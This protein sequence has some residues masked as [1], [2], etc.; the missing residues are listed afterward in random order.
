MT[1]YGTDNPYCGIC[2]IYKRGNCGGF[3]PDCEV[4]ELSDSSVMSALQGHELLR[5]NPL[6]RSALL[7]GSSTGVLIMKG[8]YLCVTLKDTEEYEKTESLK[9]LTGS[10][11]ILESDD[12]PLKTTARYLEFKRKT[13]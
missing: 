12:D 11:P 7:A 8:D 13:N 10:K 2:Q 4:L 3:D 1:R 6:L 9:R 5:E